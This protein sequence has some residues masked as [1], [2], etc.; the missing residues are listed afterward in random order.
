MEIVLFINVGL[1]LVS[2]LHVWIFGWVE[3][4]V[5]E[6]ELIVMLFVKYG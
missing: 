1:G 2:G 6:F 4:S 3:V 5:F